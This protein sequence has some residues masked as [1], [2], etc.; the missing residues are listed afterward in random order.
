[1][2]SRRRGRGAAMLWFILV[3]LPMLAFG[4][5]LAVDISRLIVSAREASNATEAAAVAGAQQYQPNTFRLDPGKVAPKVGESL[6]QSV[7]SGAMR[8]PV[9]SVTAVVTDNGYGPV[10]RGTQRVTV[11]TRYVVDDLVFLPLLGL[12]TGG[13]YNNS[14]EL[15]MTRSADVCLPGQYGPTGGSCTR[16]TA[17]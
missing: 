11:T 13:S 2:P 8:S 3:A 16:P 7:S 1:M 17:R 6:A 5:A 12:M 9:T 15:Q 10:G 14:Q 4:S